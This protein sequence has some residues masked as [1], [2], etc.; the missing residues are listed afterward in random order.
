MT[1]GF[2]IDNRRCIGCHACTV[3][4]KSEHAVPIGV[5]RTWVKYIEKGEFPSAQR[6][7]TVMRC[8]HCMDAPCVEI[9]PVAALFTREDGIVDF[10]NR[11]CIGCRAC[12]QA[13]PYDALFI[14][15]DNHTAAKCNYC[16]HRIEI[17]LEPACVLVCPER[18]IIAGDLDH[19]QS[20]IS[21]LLNTQ[22]VQVRKPEKGTRPKLFYIDADEAAL[23]PIYAEQTSGYLWSAQAQGVGHNVN[24]TQVPVLS[25]KENAISDLRELVGE[26]NVRP[27]WWNLLVSP[28]KARRVYDAPSKGVMWGWEVPAYIWTKAIASGTG[29]LTFMLPVAGMADERLEWHGVIVSFVFLCLT[30]LLLVYDLDRPDRF[31]NVLFR[32]QWKSWLVKGAYTLT[33]FGG[34]LTFWV[35]AK[36]FAW[37]SIS[38]AIGLLAIPFAFLGSV[39]TAF[40]FGQAKG[41]DAWQSPMLPAHMF[42]HSIVA[43]SAALLFTATLAGCLDERSEA[44]LGATLLWTIAAYALLSLSELFMR[45]TTQDATLASK[46]I[47]RGKYKTVYWIGVILVGSVFPIVLLALVQG[48]AIPA[49]ASLCALVG[50]A[51]SNYVSVRVP[52]LIP[53]S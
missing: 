16:A 25:E 18:A 9:C 53:L 28:E 39:Y 7:F 26:P 21:G 6:T 51:V 36:L 46:I 44:S 24:A 15:P 50:V 48:E 43:G 41:R 2:I 23:S 19:P 5:N 38:W 34:L 17:G 32:P 35:V 45:H 20:E 40:L 3:A 1:F 47:T 42:L 29:L 30:G 31:L 27:S 4:C 11:R 49:L 8:N 22:R 10:D 14:N 52:Q 12:M 37:H 13:C 33:A